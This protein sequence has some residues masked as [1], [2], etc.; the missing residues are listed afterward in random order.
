[1]IETILQLSKKYHGNWDKIYQAIAL[2]EKV[3][4]FDENLINKSNYIFI[5]DNDYPDKLKNIFV[6]PFFLF[7]IG[8]KNLIDSNVISI[9]GQINIKEMRDF[10]S[11]D[12]LKNHTIC[13]NYHEINSK[14]L[15]LIIEK[16]R[17]LIL[18]VEGG[19]DNFDYQ[20][21]NLDDM[22]D[23]ILIISEY[24]DA[25]YYDKSDNQTIERLMFAFS[26]TILINNYE[27]LLAKKLLSNLVNVEKPV[28]CLEKYKS[29]IVFLKLNNS[30]IE[31]INSF[32]DIK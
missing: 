22:N 23:N 24:N 18:I 9:N 1:M 2:K 26:D 16:K 17:K 4:S 20:F 25:N 15:N 3:D 30:K 32:K 8:N 5:T 14:V 29:K 11:I 27:L 12:Q 21:D 6:P 10:L 13:L 7:Y 28:Y 31:Y 19:I